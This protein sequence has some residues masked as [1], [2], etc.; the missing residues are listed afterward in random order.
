MGGVRKYFVS[1]RAEKMNM[2]MRTYGDNGLKMNGVS[3]CGMRFT[4]PPVA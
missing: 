3:F 2:S 4:P 1:L